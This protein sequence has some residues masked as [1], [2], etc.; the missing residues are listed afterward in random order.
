MY[1]NIRHRLCLLLVLAFNASTMIAQILEG[2]KVEIEE[3]IENIGIEGENSPFFDAFEYYTQFPINIYNAT[4]K[5]I[6]RLPGFSGLTARRIIKLSKTLKKITHRNIIDSLQLTDDQ[7]IVLERCTV[8]EEIPA[9]HV[10][11]RIRM[12][13]RVQQVRGIEEGK[14]AGSSDDIYQRWTFRENSYSAN[15]L[16]SKDAGEL[17]SSNFLSG[18]AKYTS[19]TTTAIVGD[20]SL[21][22]GLGSI[23]WQNF[24]LKKGAEVFAPLRVWGNGIQ[25]YRSAVEAGFFR[26][27]AVSKDLNLSDSI[28]VELVAWVSSV[29]RSGTVDSTLGIATSLN[30]TGLFRTEAERTRQGNIAEYMTGFSAKMTIFSALTL[31]FASFYLDYQYPIRSSSS[32]SIDGKNGLLSSFYGLWSSNTM[33]TAFEI[34]RDSKG[35][36]GLQINSLMRHELTS[37]GSQFRIFGSNFRSPFG[38]H[39]GEFSSPNNEIGLYFAVQHRPKNQRCSYVFFCDV[40]RSFEPRHLMPFPTRGLDVFGEMQWNEK[41]RGAIIRVRYEDKTNAISDDDNSRKAAQERRASLRTEWK[42]N[43]AS[44]MIESRF[45]L[46]GVALNFDTE[47]PTEYG[48][49]GFMDIRVRLGEKLAVYSRL[50]YFNTE[51]YSTARWAYEPNI[52]GIISTTAHFG[53]GQRTFVV[54]E[55]KAADYATITAKYSLT[56]RSDIAQ[57]GSGF[58]RLT[59]NNDSRIS[60]QMDV[61]L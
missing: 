26:G 18:H 46:E 40:Y 47:K 60:M 54:A 56:S 5:E 34:S 4:E 61:E 51:S 25:G 9:R 7:K 13:Q 2:E 49:L 50:A 33:R 37:I 53:R 19:A 23:L 24:G 20:Y 3:L 10:F 43:I 1:C 15:V 11:G 6:S 17:W 39:F 36:M 14:Y 42:Q 57:I 48:I 55:W 16:L 52:P 38:Y 28:A 12:Q 27:A 59:G 30:G 35:N 58:D 21:Q 45:R 31:G 41:G 32:S 44:S 22:Y 29:K 8:L